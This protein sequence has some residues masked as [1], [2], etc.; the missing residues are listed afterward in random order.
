MGSSVA[1]EAFFRDYIAARKPVIIRGHLSE[2]E[3][4]KG[5]KLWTNEYLKAKAGD[6]PLKVEKREG[7]SDRFGQGKEV[8]MT[9][10][11]FLEEFEAGNENLYLTTQVRRTLSYH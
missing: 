3:G 1:P 2:S 5:T 11:E 8:D 10:G 9:F 6:A 4:W 7:P